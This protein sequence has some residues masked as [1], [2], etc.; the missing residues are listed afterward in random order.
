MLKTRVLGIDFGLAR[1]GLA[2]SDPLRVIASPLENLAATHSLEKTVEALV[3]YIAKLKSDKGYSIGEIVVGLPLH[4][5]GSESER[6]QIVRQFASLLESK[7]E[8]KVQLLDER[9]S[10]VQADR[11]LMET[12]FSR[13]KRAQVVDRVS[14]VIILQTFLNQK[15]RL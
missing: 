13:K 10:S 6:S 5:D 2:I 7:A 9:L 12:G 1:I 4:M 14:A 15:A 3:A 11:A 8:L